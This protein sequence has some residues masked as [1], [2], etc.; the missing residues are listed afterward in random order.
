MEYEVVDR[1][2]R[3]FRMEKVEIHWDGQAVTLPEGIVW[4]GTVNPVWR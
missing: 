2:Q 1:F 3:I 4:E